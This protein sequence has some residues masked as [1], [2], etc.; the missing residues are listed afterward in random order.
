[1]KIGQLLR[2]IRTNKSMSLAQ[3][4][5]AQISSSY[6]SKIERD[7][8]DI[9]VTKLAHLLERLSTTP[10]EFLFLVTAGREH[11]YATRDRLLGTYFGQTLELSADPKD[12]PKAIQVMKEEISRAQAAF[13]RHPNL[14]QQLAVNARVVI[15]ATFQSLV[16]DK[17]H[18]LPIRPDLTHATEQY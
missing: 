1:M 6:R 17:A 11:D 8:S 2:T 18:Q 12:F 4:A 13:D 14:K 9:T 3:V 7:Q 10:E 15:L 16:V 5:D